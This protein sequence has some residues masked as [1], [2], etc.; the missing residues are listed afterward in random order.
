MHNYD[1]E[2]SS[3]L[4]GLLGALEDPD[5][6]KNDIWTRVQQVSIDAP[7]QVEVHKVRL[8]IKQTLE[9]LL[10]EEQYDDEGPEPLFDAD[11]FEE[12]Q[13]GARH[14]DY[15]LGSEQF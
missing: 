8:D 5:A 6:Y 11:A 12:L 4:F 1:G 13:V 10:D 14:E 15:E 2:V 3:L 9:D 7:D